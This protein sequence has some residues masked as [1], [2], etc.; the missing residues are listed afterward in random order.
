MRYANTTSGDQVAGNSPLALD[1]WHHL[2]AT[3]DSAAAVESVYLDTALLGQK[4]SSLALPD[5]GISFTI[6][7]QNCSC[8]FTIAFRGDLDEVAIYATALSPERI[9]A[10]YDAA[11]K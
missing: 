2:V 9:K 3:Y 5:Q 4:A 11:M 6:G 10:H 7:N 1:R 8:D